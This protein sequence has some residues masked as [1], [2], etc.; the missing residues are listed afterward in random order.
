M[1]ANFLK[2][3]NGVDVMPLM[4]QLQSQ[5]HLWNRNKARLLKTGPHWQTH[6]I[7]VRYKD[8]A[9]NV[10]SGD[11]ANFA[12]EH[13][14]IWYPSYY[15]LPAIKPL[16]FALMARVEGERLGGI[17][18]YKVEPGK[19]ILPHTDTGWHADFYDKFNISIQSQPGCVFHYE[20]EEMHSVTGDVYWYMN[21]KDHWITNTSDRDQIVMSVSIRTH[22]YGDR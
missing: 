1:A 12:D 21:D 2:I 5:P 7:W 6:D 9:E 14:P 19:E 3:G 4:L 20:G 8:D 16:V 18:L 13:D 10:A 17:L 11:W 22:K 15:A